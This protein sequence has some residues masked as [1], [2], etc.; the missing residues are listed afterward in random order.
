MK[1]CILT[2]ATNK[3]IQFVE[4]LYNNL[5]ENFLNGHELEC[6][7]FTEHDVETSDNVK[8]SKIDHEPWP[9]PTLK[10]YNYFVKE[11]EY[12]SKFDY[13]YY[14]DVDMGIVEKVGDEVLGDLVATMHPYQSLYPKESRS[15]D[16]N[17]NSLA[18]V[19]PGEEGE[20]YYAGGFNGGKTECFLKMAEVIA[21][22]VNQDLEKDVIALWHDESQMNRYLIDNPPTL[23]LT[24]TYCFAEEQM[25][26]PNY[27]YEPKII[28]LKKNHNELRS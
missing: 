22:R 2:I 15:Y 10:R 6:L 8:V 1:I 7:L 27:P 26:N 12:I 4:R 24:P 21:D 23:S 5:E 17:P 18:F 25:G 9:M 19:P 14:F 11:K 20:N 3:Y 28:A 16:R 13:C